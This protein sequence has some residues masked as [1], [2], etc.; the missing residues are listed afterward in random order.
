MVTT[1]L[2]WFNSGG[3]VPNAADY[4]MILVPDQVYKGSLRRIG[5]V[6][7][8][9]GWQTFS[10]A[11]NHVTQLGYPTNFDNGEI[12]HQVTSGAFQQAARN[13]VE[14]GSDM[15]QGSSGGPWIQNFSELADGQAGVGLT[16]G[17]PRV[18]GVTSYAYDAAEP[19]SLG[20][21]IPDG[22]WSKLFNRYCRLSPSNCS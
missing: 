8:W 7:G 3:D 16:A 13:N 4:A 18:V 15:R 10:L 11:P 12:M 5:D 14:Y 21:S 17:I 2:K 1:P 20:A 6:V 9:Y 19:L 22:R